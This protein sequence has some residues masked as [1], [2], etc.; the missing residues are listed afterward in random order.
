MSRQR[1]AE[2][3]GR[4]EGLSERWEWEWEPA[5][6]PAGAGVGCRLAAGSWAPGQALQQLGDTSVVDSNPA[7][8][9]LTP[10]NPESPAMGH[11]DVAY[12]LPWMPKSQISAAVM[13]FMGP[14]FGVGLHRRGLLFGH[15]AR[16]RGVVSRS[17][18]YLV[19][20]LVIAGHPPQPGSVPERLGGA[21]QISEA[22][23]T[24]KCPRS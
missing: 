3:G 4:E 22:D 5:W 9:F 18:F 2:G 10:Q 20:V 23:A 14:N 21:W 12:L 6:E 7:F 15:G 13:S 24:R 8:Q 19:P 1:R 17:G 11:V 16:L